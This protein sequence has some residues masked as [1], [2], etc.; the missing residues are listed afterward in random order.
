V[1]TALLCAAVHAQTTSSALNSKVFETVWSTVNKYFYDAKFN[2]VDWQAAH[3]KYAPLAQSAKTDDE[4]YKTINEM[5]AL[6]KVSH[7]EADPP[8]T[9][10]KLKQPPTSTGVGLRMVEGRPTITRLLRGFPAEN[11]GLKTGYV[12]T[13]VDNVEVENADDTRK[14]LSGGAGTTVKIKYLDENDSRHETVLARKSLSDTDRGKLEGLNFYALFDSKRLDNGIGYI[15]FTSF[16]PFLNDR[17]RASIGSM[18]TA[19]GLI[20]DLRGNSGGDDSVAIGIANQLFDKPTELMITRLRKGEDHYYKTKPAKD[21]Y[22]GKLVVLVNETS[23]S[24]SEQLTAGLQE[25]GRAYVIGTKTAGADL[26]ADIKMLPDGGFLVYAAGLPHTPK[27][28]V[29]EGRGIIP[30]MVVELK[31]ADLLKGKDTQLQAAID[32]LRK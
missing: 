31:R 10:A 14:L 1:V 21:P 17:I 22:L 32:Y 20:I 26:D 23:S 2:G 15:W 7:M 5:L 27:G 12:I 4:L 6:L 8:S 30:D 16:L 24:A 3:D 19:P 9:V 28:V 29:I 11:S 13:A 18:K 25:A